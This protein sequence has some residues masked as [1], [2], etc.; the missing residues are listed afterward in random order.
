MKN[1]LKVTF[2]E[3]LD[4]KV[5]RFAKLPRGLFPMDGEYFRLFWELNQIFIAGLYYSTIVLTGVLCE[6]ICL[7]LL[8]QH[9][10]TLKKDGLYEL[11]NCLSD[12]KLIKSNSQKEMEKIRKKRNKY[13]HPK[14][15]KKPVEKDALEIIESIS[16]VLRN[17]IQ[18]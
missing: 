8:D 18:K 4:E 13:V 15:G 11:I 1:Y 9:S 10:I 14:T 5:D 12:K 2:A 3:D 7:D 6:R 17:E 16:I